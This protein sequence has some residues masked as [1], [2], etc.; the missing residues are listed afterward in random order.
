MRKYLLFISIIIFL[1]SSKLFINSAYPQNSTYNFSQIA[2]MEDNTNKVDRLLSLALKYRKINLDSSLLCANLALDLAQGIDYPIGIAEAYYKM[3]LAYGHHSD[4]NNAMI[5]ARKSLEVAESIPDSLMIAKV[6]YKLGLLILYGSYNISAIDNFKL[7]FHIF[8]QKNDTAHAA[9]VCNGLG[10]YFELI[11]LY[12]SAAIYFHKSLELS[13]PKTHPFNIAKVQS[14]LGKV[15]RMLKEYDLAREYLNMAY[16]EIIKFGDFEEIGR[17][18]NKMG[19]LEV[20]VMNYEGAEEYFIKADSNFR[21]VKS[22]VGISN[23]QVNLAGLYHLQGLSDKSLG[24]YDSAITYYREF[25][26]PEGLIVAWDG[27]AAVYVSKGNLEIALSYSDSC[28]NL[29]RQTK[30]MKRQEEVLNKLITIYAEMEDWQEVAKTHNLLHSIKDSIYS[31]EKAQT[32]HNLD[33]KYNKEKDKVKILDLQNKNLQRTKQRNAFLIIGAGLIIFAFYL[34]YFFRYKAKKNRIISDQKIQQLQ[35]EKK[36]L[37]ARFLVEGQEKERKR[38]ASAIHDSLGV[39]LST[40]KMHITSIKD[41]DP[42]NRELIEKATKYLDEANTEMRKISHN[43]MPGSLSKLGLCEALDDLFDTLDDAEG[44]DASMEVVGPKERL[45]E[46]QEIMIYRVVQEMVNNTIKHAKASKI[47]LTLIVHP[48]EVDISYAD[49]GK[50][51]V[52]DEVLSMKTMGVQSIR[53]R[54]KFLDGRLN[55]ESAPGKGVVYRIS[56]PMDQDTGMKSV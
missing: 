9:T 56:I 38:I 15:Y 48:D 44:M 35:E 25:D 4:D 49:N 53:S 17:W 1:T 34:F 42:K 11:T 33:L 36:L 19:S 46:N 7:A 21:V 24:K 10:S 51:F 45:P 14:N 16:D 39:L 5:Y 28:L 13:G 31:L 23:C 6:N 37:A 30:N 2:G 18:Y 43:M 12:D 40:S 27:K 22:G 29:A 8:L 50:G 32:I 55:I 47:S 3:S 20:E 54:V 26:I 52:V 41:D